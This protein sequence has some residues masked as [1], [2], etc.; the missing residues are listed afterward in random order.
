MQPTACN[1]TPQRGWYVRAILALTAFI[2]FPNARWIIITTLAVVSLLTNHL[3]RLTFRVCTLNDF[4]F[5][6]WRTRLTS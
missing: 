5:L 3:S 1:A 6:D 2:S 4:L